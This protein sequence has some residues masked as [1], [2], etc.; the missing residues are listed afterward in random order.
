LASLSL[1]LDNLW[2]YLKVRNDPRWARYPTYLPVLVPRVLAF[3]RRKQLG[4]TFFVVGRDAQQEANEQPL[5]QI[6]ESGHEIGNH[7]LNHDPWMHHYGEQ[8]VVQEI[9]DAEREIERVTGCKPL[10]FRGPGF[11][12]SPIILRVLQQRGYQYDASLLPSVLGPIARLFY[13]WRTGMSRE[14]RKKRRDLFGPMSNGFM[15]LK[16][17]H[18][19]LAESHLL[20]IPVTTVPLLRIPF[21][22]SHLLWLSR[23]SEAL[24]S[25][26]LTFALLIC[27]LRNVEP[28]FLLHPLDFLGKEDAPEL[29]FFPAMDLPRA[30]KL[31]MV[32]RLIDN[33]LRHFHVEPM[34]EHARQI[35]DR[36]RLKT[37][38][39]MVLRA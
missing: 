4:I 19:E 11:C 16:A 13:L 15:P 2:S 12:A 30:R 10:G 36:G 17:F 37:L 14:D 24:A 22:L 34:T 27:R 3:L 25:S 8:Q 35:R 20:E 5:R 32:E 23:F 18:W 1:D 33:F 28:S 29:G 38:E 6:A 39:P 7:S 31:E 9:A 26:Y 21:H